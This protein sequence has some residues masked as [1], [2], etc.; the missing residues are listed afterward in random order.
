M[1]GYQDIKLRGE[2]IVEAELN[3][4]ADELVG[5]YEDE[6]GTYQPITHM[7]LSTSAVLGWGSKSKI[8]F[9]TNPR[10][11]LYIFW[12]QLFYF[13]SALLKTAWK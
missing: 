9:T 2:M 3:V 13:H 6:L 5:Q 11:L 4:V 7:Y 12:K 8:L 10:F 1:Y